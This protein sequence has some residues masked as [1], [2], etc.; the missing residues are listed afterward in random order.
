MLGG[1]A[2]VGEFYGNNNKCPFKWYDIGL[3]LVR[4]FGISRQLK[5]RVYVC[6]CV[7]YTYIDI[8]LISARATVCVS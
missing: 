7:S 3:R 4:R 6:V 1:Y 2:F 8:T 5:F